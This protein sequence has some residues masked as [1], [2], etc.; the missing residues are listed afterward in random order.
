MSTLLHTYCFLLHTVTRCYALYSTVIPNLSEPFSGSAEYE[1][2]FYDAN[3]DPDESV[4]VQDLFADPMAKGKQHLYF[5]RDIG[6]DGKW[7]FTVAHT[8]LAFEHAAREI[9]EGVVHFSL[10]LYVDGTSQSLNGEI[11]KFAL[12]TSQPTLRPES[13]RNGGRHLLSDSKL[14]TF[15]RRLETRL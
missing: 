14:A 8:C 7:R 13:L 9:G 3:H 10:V 6:P 2:S 11:Y 15:W 12:C 1:D 4:E 5:Q